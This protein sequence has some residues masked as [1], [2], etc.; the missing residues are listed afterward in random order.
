MNEEKLDVFTALLAET[1]VDFINLGEV[2]SGEIIID[3]TTYGST[4]DYST[5]YN[6][7]IGDLMSDSH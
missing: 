5:K 3:E 1:N 7:A 6:N 2:T 4:S